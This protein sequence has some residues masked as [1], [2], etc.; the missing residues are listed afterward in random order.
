MPGYPS[1][2]AMTQVV[3]KMVKLMQADEKLA[4]AIKSQNFS[5]TTDITDLKARYYI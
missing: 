1:P 5:F 4:A 3:D 2:E